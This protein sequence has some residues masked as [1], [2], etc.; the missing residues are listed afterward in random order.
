MGILSMYSTGFIQVIL[1][2]WRVVIFPVF[3]YYTSVTFFNFVTLIESASFNNNLHILLIFRYMLECFVE[4]Q[5]AG[6]VT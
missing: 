4:F 2:K 6:N 1:P 5:K 3:K